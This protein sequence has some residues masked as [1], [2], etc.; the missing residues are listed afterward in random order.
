VTSREHLLS[1]I[2]PTLLTALALGIIVLAPA[3]RPDRTFVE[4][5]DEVK[6]IIQDRFYG[7]VKES[8]LVYSALE[9]MTEAL[10]Q[11]SDF[12][13]PDEV[14]DLTESN[15]GKFGGIGVIVDE[16]DQ[17]YTYVSATIERLPA[18]RAGIKPG[19]R[20]VSVD[21]VST[22]GE[23]LGQI[24][25][26]VKGAV[27][28]PVRIGIRR[29]GEESV[30]EFTVV[31]EEVL[32]PSVV[33][34]RMVD[35]ER[36]IGYV[37][38]LQFQEGSGEDLAVAV[39]GLL[40]KG[41]RSLV[42]DMRSNPGGI[43]QAAVDVAGI[44]LPEDALV[45]NVV[46]KSDSGERRVEEDEGRDD[47]PLVIL[48][49]ERSAS[50]SEIVAGAVQDH[51]RGILVGARTYGKAS[52]Q[53]LIQVLDDTAVLKLTTAEYRTPKGRMIHRDRG[54]GEDDPWGLIPDVKSEFDVRVFFHLRRL[55]DRRDTAALGHLEVDPE[56]IRKEIEKIPDGEG[57]K[58]EKVLMRQAL[59][60]F[61]GEE[62]DPQLQ[63]ALRILRD[64]SEY[65]SILAGGSPSR[66][67]AK[68]D[69]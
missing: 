30:R 45:V 20:I 24:I 65:E 35:E 49:N 54:D 12:I 47:F 25:R 34:T 36:K 58:E 50:A 39:E 68:G 11:H 63:E 32:V 4:Q 16:D 23:H 40:V 48:V 66:R 3:L 10:D 21:G 17:G 56:E 31:R 52:V 60:V 62:P 13:W 2:A 61:Q 28:T 7:E 41:M 8:D 38:L 53:T 22:E 55:W 14:A 43:L 64:P 15:E 5:A 59:R 57:G 27:G 9:G 6:R 44:F 69:E 42:L 46:G 67:T 18:I 19:D 37:R 29:A 33:A 51:R 1:W 26:R